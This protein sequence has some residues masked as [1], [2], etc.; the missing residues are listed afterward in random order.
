MLFRRKTHT[1]GGHIRYMQT[2]KGVV[3][4][5]RDPYHTESVFDIEDGLRE[6]PAYE[7]SLEFVR[8]DP[9]IR[10]LMD[11]RYL[12]PAADVQALSRCADGTLGKVYANH[13]IDNG[14]DADYFRKIEVKT[15]LDWMLMRI[16][17]THDIWHVVTGLGVGPFGELGLKSFELSQTRRPMAAIITTGGVIRYLLHTPEELGETLDYIAYGYRL[18]NEAKPFLA[19]RW[20]ERWDEPLTEL[21]RALDVHPDEIPYAVETIPPTSAAE[22]LDEAPP[23]EVDV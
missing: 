3:T 5:L 21:R 16:R 23:Q 7:K 8:A 22:T 11:S 9:G 20:E 1:H 13:I 18:G 17:Q 15:D 4:M 12:A 2:L 19:Q 10:S 6:I 14:F